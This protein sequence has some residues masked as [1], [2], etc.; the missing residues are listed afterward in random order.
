MKV[1]WQF[2]GR[3][4]GAGVHRRAARGT[5]RLAFGPGRDL[6]AEAGRRPGPAGRDL[7]PDSGDPPAKPADGRLPGP[8]EVPVQFTP[9]DFDQAFE[10]GA[11]VVKAI[12][13]PT[14]RTRKWPSLVSRP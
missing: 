1:G 14:R 9:E 10:G 5:R 11:L 7:L 3:T 6:P 13:L 12:Y 4:G 8:R 2:V